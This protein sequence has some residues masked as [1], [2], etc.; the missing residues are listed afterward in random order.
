[1]KW[2]RPPGSLG[3]KP[4]PCHPISS[5]V[6]GVAQLYHFEGYVL[7]QRCLFRPCC[8]CCFSGSFQHVSIRMWSHKTE[9]LKKSTIYFL[10]NSCTE[11]F[12]V[13]YLVKS[14]DCFILLVR[15]KR[16]N[17]LNNENHIPS[18]QLVITKSGILSSENAMLP[19]KLFGRPSCYLQFLNWFQV[20]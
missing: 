17:L 18:F 13:C 15:K 19:T 7:L 20:F 1:M 3:W 6:H 10:L 8:G 16:A 11:A 12:R 14:F 9:I 4:S 2:C 5:F